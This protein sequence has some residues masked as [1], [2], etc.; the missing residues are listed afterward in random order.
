MIG[1]HSELD[2]AARG[3]TT[4]DAPAPLVVE[5]IADDLEWL[6]EVVR[7]YPLLAWQPWDSPRTSQRKIL[8]DL[9]WAVFF[10][11]FI[12]G[13]N[14]SGKT[15]L[16]K[17]LCVVYALGR[18]HP[19]VAAWATMIDIDL[20]AL[21]VPLG[22]GK[23]FLIA[24]SSGDSIR[25]HRD[26]INN[27]LPRSAKRWRNRHGRGEAVVTIHVPGYPDERAEIWFKS[28]D[29]RREG[30]QGDSIRAAFVDEEIG[31]GVW[32]ELLL[33]VAD[34]A[35]VIFCAMTPLKGLTWVYKRYTGQV[36]PAEE[37]SSAFWLD[38]LDNPH[39]PREFFER[40]YRSMTPAEI[41]ARRHGQFVTLS[42]RVYP[43]WARGTHLCEHMEIP[44]E[45]PRYRAADFGARHHT[46]V[47]WAALGPDGMLY[48]YREL[49]A[50]GLTTKQLARRVH[51][52][53]GHIWVPE[54]VLGANEQVP[55]VQ[56]FY[57]ETHGSTR[58]LLGHWDHSRGEVIVGHACDSSAKQMRRDLASHGVVFNKANRDWKLGKSCVIDR[59]NL[60]VDNEPRLK[61]VCRP[62]G[63]PCAPH[64]VKE[65]EGY[66]DPRDDTAGDTPPPRPITGDDAM[67]TLRYLC[68]LVRML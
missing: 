45:W 2:A 50:S 19:M 9:A 41:A 18:D 62:D 13:G 7:E 12:F 23:V 56:Q 54:R 1:P 33:R 42:G 6:S 66:V 20:E 21:G 3:A 36:G 35:G 5:D 11:C 8:K 52:A 4:P 49:Y 17:V 27:L 48:I 53:E 34:Q 16:L 15:E 40:L 37:G 38:A 32:D 31:E 57:V 46:C 28:E 22:P 51:K 43:M 39:L 26:D 65:I 64:M 14:R 60:E 61:V 58:T 25:Y 63:R 24:K 67:D 10:V 29:Q 59:L 55:K 30:M 44:P 68:W 47:L